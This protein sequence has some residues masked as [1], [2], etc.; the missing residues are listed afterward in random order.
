MRVHR[1]TG[2]SR[3]VIP[4]QPAMCCK[5]CIGAK[6]LALD[7]CKDLDMCNSK[8][9]FSLLVASLDLNNEVR[10]WCSILQLPRSDVSGNGVCVLGTCQCLNGFS[11]PTCADENPSTGGKQPWYQSIWLMGI[12]G[13]VFLIGGLGLIFLMSHHREYGKPGVRLVLF[14]APHF[15]DV[16]LNRV[17]LNKLTG[18]YVQPADSIL[19]QVT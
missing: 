2:K 12:L 1:E 6:V 9:I 14:E 13:C 19:C 11:G 4:L 5:L 3:H 16:C 8:C 10:T 18:C 7:K 17:D 15:C